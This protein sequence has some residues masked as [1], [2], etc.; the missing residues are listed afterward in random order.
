MNA[1]LFK[2]LVALVPAGVL[3]V[4]SLLLLRRERNLGSFLQL[5]G[6]GCVVVVVLTHVCEALHLFPW[7]HWGSEHSVGHY[8]DLWSA[9]LAI[10]LFP[11]RYLLHALTKRHA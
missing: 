2:A 9:V 4:G 7:M 5:L 1:T 3:F 6:S 8:L 11:V 10:T